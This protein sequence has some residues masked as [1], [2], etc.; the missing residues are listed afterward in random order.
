MCNSNA[1][2]HLSKTQISKIKQ[3]ERSVW[4]FLKPVLDVNLALNAFERH[5]ENIT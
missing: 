1:N 2:I 4:V 3:L 5:F